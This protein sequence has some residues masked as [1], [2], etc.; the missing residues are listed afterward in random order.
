MSIDKFLV[1]LNSFLENKLS[2][3]SAFKEQGEVYESFDGYL[4][5]ITK[6]KYDSITSEVIF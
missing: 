3:S 2:D 4:R 5:K 1:E 6:S